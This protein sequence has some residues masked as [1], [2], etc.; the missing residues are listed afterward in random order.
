MGRALGTLF[1]DQVPRVR[2]TVLG[3]G[4][5]GLIPKDPR[6]KGLITGN[7]SNKRSNV[8]KG[9]YNIRPAI[10]FLCMYL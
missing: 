7:L 9:L 10:V 1:T 8:T 3:V 4:T 2:G 6:I 5:K